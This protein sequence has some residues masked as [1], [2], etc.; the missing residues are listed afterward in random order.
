M[1]KNTISACMSEVLIKQ[2]RYVAVL[3]REDI[4][5]QI[6][7]TPII[8]IPKVEMTKVDE[9]TDM[10]AVKYDDMTLKFHLH[11]KNSQDGTRHV[12]KDVTSVEEQP[13]AAMEC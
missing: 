9:N 12:V 13:K 8:R 10:V 4:I 3:K 2:C 5:R 11:W 7:G 1:G 6:Q